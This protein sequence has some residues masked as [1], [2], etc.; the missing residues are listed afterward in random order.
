MAINKFIRAIIEGKEI[1]VYGDGKQTRDFT[2]ID[3]VVKANISAAESKFKGETFNIGGGNT[4]NVLELIKNIE[5]ITGKKAVINKLEKQRGDV[6][7]T[8]ADVRKVQKQLKWSPQVKIKD[9]LTI[10]I[11]WLKNNN[12]I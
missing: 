5:Y 12:Y 2:Y 6:K 8:L 1:N 3:D 9:G 7:D 4:I 10:Y 11:N